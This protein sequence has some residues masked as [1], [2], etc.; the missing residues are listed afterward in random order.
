MTAGAPPPA[1]SQPVRRTSVTEPAWPAGTILLPF[2]NLEGLPLITGTLRG[3]RG[4]DTTGLFALDTG[5]GY[6]T[7]DRALASWAGLIDSTADPGPIGI[8]IHPLPRLKIGELELD[9]L[10]PVMTVDGEIVRAVTDR[11]VLGL[12]GER[13]LADRAV[14][15]DFG[16]EKI[17]LIPVS[18]SDSLSRAPQGQRIQASHAALVAIMGARARPLAFR[19]AGD[20]KILLQARI[21]SSESSPSGAP[22]T[23]ILD[24]GATKCVLFQPSLGQR[25]PGYRRWPTVEGLAAPTL[26]GV[27]SASIA[28]VPRL[29]IGADAGAIVVRGLDAAILRSELSDQLSQVVGERVDGL[30][31][32]SFLS[33]YLVVIDYPHR[34]LWLDRERGGSNPRPFEYCHVGLQLERRDHSLQVVALVRRSPAEHAGIRVGDVLEMIDGAPVRDLD[35]STV[36]RRLEGPPGTPVLIELR[37]DG[38][39]ARYR[40]TRRRLL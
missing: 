28:R 25:V 14:W 22:L 26:I 35:V 12:L 7:L 16:S 4:R 32:A 3:R 5:A 37:R 30:L 18:S 9:Q 23:F 38:A 13:P 19:L 1:Q 33:R 34:V 6:L 17:A 21:A 8:A 29:E 24:T 15:I 40:L 20:G 11:N 10:N 39:A 36:N 27:S 31:G 2:E